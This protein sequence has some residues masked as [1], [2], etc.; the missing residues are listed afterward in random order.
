MGSAIIRLMRRV[1]M[2]QQLRLRRAG[3]LSERLR[4]ILNH[5]R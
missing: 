4:R 5:H 3:V 1:A 2:W